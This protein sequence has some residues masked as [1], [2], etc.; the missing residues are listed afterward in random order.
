M[1]ASHRSNLRKHPVV[2]DRPIA[3]LQPKLAS[4]LPLKVDAEAPSVRCSCL[5]CPAHELNLCAAAK[6]KGGPDSDRRSDAPQLASTVYTIPAR[7]SICH[8]KEWSEFVPI[9]C[10][11]WAASSIALPDG[12][13]QI[14]SF[15]LPGDIVSMASLLEPTH[16]RSVQAITQVTYRNFRRS[17]IKFNLLTFSDLL[18]RVARICNEERAQADQLALDLGRRTA[19]ERIA[20]L[21]SGLV[22]KLAKRGMT[23]GRTME[24]PLRQR[25]IADATGLSLVHVGKVLGKFQEAGLIEINGRSLT[26]VNEMELRGVAGWP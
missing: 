18:E 5:A 4:L 9:V 2:K 3:S 23:N 25:H 1:E 20:R 10:D 24:F 13:R 17:E 8:P 21:I 7:R 22:D 26:I 16:G 19:Y 14:L 6:T 12:R 11:G 15:L